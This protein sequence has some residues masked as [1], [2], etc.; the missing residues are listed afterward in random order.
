M[1]VSAL[2]L[3]VALVAI[4]C[5]SG[6]VPT[7]TA[8]TE[9]STA[10]DGSAAAEAP[11]GPELREPR[12]VSADEAAAAIERVDALAAAVSVAFDDDVAGFAAALLA[13]D[14]GYSLDQI[15]DAAKVGRLVANGDVVEGDGSPTPPAGTG[16]KLLVDDRTGGSA[17]D[18][19]AQNRDASG[20]RIVKISEIVGP[21]NEGSKQEGL[22]VFL[23]MFMALETGYAPD[24][25]ITQILAGGNVVFVD[26][27]DQKDTVNPTSPFVM[28]LLDEHDRVIKPGLGDFSD[29]SFPL[30]GLTGHQIVSDP[31]PQ[32][33]G[34][35]PAST[36]STD[37]EPAD[38]EAAS[39]LD[40]RVQ[41]AAGAYLIDPETATVIEQA[42]PG[43]DGVE[44]SVDVSGQIVIGGD[45]S[46]GGQLRYRVTKTV[47]TL[48]DDYHTW[49]WEEITLEPTTLSVLDDG[50]Y[51][52]AIS[53]IAGGWGAD[54]IEDKLGT[55][56]DRHAQGYVDVD[57]GQL[58]VTGVR[59]SP[60]VDTTH[61]Q[62]AG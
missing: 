41:A 6:S 20:K 39:E 9:T 61:W 12:E 51:F 45:G 7:D 28:L 47:A 62:L 17:P 30:S 13:Q 48:A 27:E 55:Y 40:A 42:T 34:A 15:S 35:E 58:V 60:A 10:V 21:I 43:E 2:V 37:A 52:D 24:Q 8:T 4:G 11:T 18:E 50:L 59:V 19:A 46:V 38:V 25:V 54:N 16:A 33:S 32:A 31:E 14:R 44:I 36:P 57:L 22:G 53:T 1:K 3:A 26:F 56:S 23:T 5:S 49:R 29:V